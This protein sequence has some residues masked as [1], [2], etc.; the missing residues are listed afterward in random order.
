MKTRAARRAP[1][2]GR[3][4]AAATNPGTSRRAGVFACP[5]GLV[6]GSV[7]NFEGD[8][9][10]FTIV[11]EAN[12]VGGGSVRGIRLRNKSRVSAGGGGGSRTRVTPEYYPVDGATGCWRATW[13]PALGGTTP[14]VPVPPEDPSQ[15][16]FKRPYL[17]DL[18]VP[19]RALF[20]LDSR[21]IQPLTPALRAG[22]SCV[23]KPTGLTIPRGV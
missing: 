2:R 5:C 3:E 15:E 17:S 20:Y 23:R 6:G 14:V 16:S 18:T 10:I 1:A 12:R 13:K 19:G 11:W 4:S 8:E 21:I 7:G 22:G 9:E